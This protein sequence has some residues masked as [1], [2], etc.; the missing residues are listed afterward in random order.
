MDEVP[1]AARLAGLFP[2]SATPPSSLS[3]ALAPDVESM[4][5]SGAM[6]M[7]LRWLA[8]FWEELKPRG[9]FIVVSV[10][11]FAV[12]SV[13]NVAVASVINVIVRFCRLMTSARWAR[14]HS[15]L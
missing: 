1:G 13:I 11:I 15:G 7:G 10:G 14:L 9:F 2:G 12:A 6:N 3:S 8:P 4:R 5:F